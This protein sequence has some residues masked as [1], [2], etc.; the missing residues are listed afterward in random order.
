MNQNFNNPIWL[1]KKQ[2]SN[3]DVIKSYTSVGLFPAEKKLIE[4]YF[5][6]G[7]N[8]LDIG[9]GAGR[10]TIALAKNGF[11]VTGIDLTHGMIEAAKY[12]AKCHKVDVNFKE[13]N[14]VNMNFK[15][16]SFQNVL[17]AFNGFDQIHGKKNREIVLRKILNILKPGGCFIFTTR[18]GLAFG[19]RTIAWALTSILYPYRKLI[20]NKNQ[21]E[22]GDKV[23]NGQYHFYV[24]P[25]QLKSKISEIGYK[26]LYF[27][28]EKN[29]VKDKK[30]NFLTNFSNDKILF[31][32]LKK[33]TN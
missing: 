26:I 10:T 32:V 22:F 11:N 9:C 1:V 31:Y 14:A 13:M 3:P 12:Q 6:P 18:S 5:K 8:V 30:P 2:Y 17:F 25:I 16:E 20:S 4:K 7:S 29:I 24:N 15:S 27:N 23:W 19:R 28:S 21:W 33:E